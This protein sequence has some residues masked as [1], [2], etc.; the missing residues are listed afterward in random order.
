MIAQLGKLGQCPLLRFAT[1]PALRDIRVP[2]DSGELEKLRQQDLTQSRKAAKKKRR[3][4][5]GQSNQASQPRIAT[6]FWRDSFAALRFCVRSEWRVTQAN[7]RNY[8]NRI[9]RKAAK[10]QK[11]KGAN[12]EGSTIS[13]QVKSTEDRSGLL[14][15][16]FCGFAASR[17]IRVPVISNTGAK[18]RAGPARKTVVSSRVSARF[19]FLRPNARKSTPPP[20]PVPAS[21]STRARGRRRQKT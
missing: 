21:R 12:E 10:P 5:R 19:S 6:D 8:V 18:K 13:E 9:S 2:G 3:K 7:L 15:S 17:E 1:F 16:L 11:R 4:R 14:A 20:R